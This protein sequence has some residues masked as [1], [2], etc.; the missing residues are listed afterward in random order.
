MFH[1]T[2]TAYEGWIQAGH[3]Q[4]AS[5]SLHT[6]GEDPATRVQA[7]DCLSAG[8]WQTASP[9]LHTAGEDPA[10]RAQTPVCLR[11]AV[12]H[13]QRASPSLQTPATAVGRQAPDCIWMAL[14]EAIRQAMANFI[15][16][17]FVI[18]LIINVNDFCVYKSQNQDVKNSIRF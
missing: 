7:L 8:H 12:G 17:D 16:G 18:L 5:P 13:W 15:L 1:D 3:W 2:V 10:T 6:A 11:A 4:T 9:S 14:T